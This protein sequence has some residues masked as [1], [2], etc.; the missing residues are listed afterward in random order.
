M[1]RQV[2]VFIYFLFVSLQPQTLTGENNGGCP[3]SPPRCHVIFVH[4]GKGWGGGGL[5]EGGDE[6]YLPVAKK[7]KHEREWERGRESNDIDL[8][9]RK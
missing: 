8:N 1:T 7:Q 2:Q 9:V 4:R 3:A 6:P 5:K